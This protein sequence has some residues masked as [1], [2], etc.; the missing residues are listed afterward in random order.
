[1]ADKDGSGQDRFVTTTGETFPSTIRLAGLG[2]QLREWTD[3][4]LPVM[5]ELFDDPQFDRWTPLASP[6]DLPAAQAYL[7]KAREQRSAGRVIQLVIT[8]DGHDALGEILLV[9]RE[10]DGPQ[11]A[12]LAYGI[13]AEHRRRRL[14]ARAVQLMTGYAYDVLAMN[15]VILRIAPDNAA[16]E[17]VARTT[18]FHLTDEDPIIRER[19]T[20]RSVRLLTWAHRPH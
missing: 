3:A 1:L 7:S 16:S 4:D 11:V 18:G 13:G 9:R 14:A 17:A 19:A 5:A 8:T 2:L 15:R 10:E 12:E 20:G 6:F